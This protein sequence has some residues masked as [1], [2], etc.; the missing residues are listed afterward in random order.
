MKKH[1]EVVVPSVPNFLK[2]GTQTVSVAEFSNNELRQ[3]GREWTE[4]LIK[5]AQTIRDANGALQI[6]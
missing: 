1:I 6:N 5:R 3:I 2:V 4:K